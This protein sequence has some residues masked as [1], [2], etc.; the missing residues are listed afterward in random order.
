[1]ILG[2][3]GFIGQALYKELLPY[4]NVHA[5]YRTERSFFEKNQ[6]FH[7]WDSD[8]ESISILL[9]SFR[10]DIII[11]AVRGNFEAQLIAHFECM[12]YAIKKN[13]KLIFLSSSN[14]F[15]AF[16]NFPSYEYDKT[17]SISVY[18]RFK[19]KIENAL[20]RLPNHNYSIVRLP[21]IFGANSP[22]VEEIKKLHEVNEPIEVFPNVVI[23]ATSINYV[24]QQIHFIINRSLEGVFHLG[25]KDL[26]HHSDLIF[27]IC[28]IL[29]IDNPLF[30]NVFNSNNDRF[31]AVLPKDNLLPKNLRFSIQDV[32]NQTILN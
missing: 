12:E 4:F 15:D 29:E 28:E 30:K 1:M 14:V 20:L 2:G 3:S 16:T 26:I 17:L 22:R 24:T 25:S 11:S 31:L 18:G 7:C 32:I 23:N 8:T 9:Q 19:I 27:E 6:H 5:T 13:A 10:P 21:M